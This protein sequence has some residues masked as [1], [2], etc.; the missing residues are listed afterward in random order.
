METG[1]LL[2]THNNKDDDKSYNEIWDVIYHNDTLYSIDGQGYLCA[3]K[4]N[5][6]T[7]ILKADKDD[8]TERGK[9]V[10][11]NDTLYVGLKHLF[12]VDLNDN[13]VKKSIQCPDD[14]FVMFVA[15]TGESLILATEGKNLYCISLLLLEGNKEY[16]EAIPN[17]ENFTT[18]LKN[19]SE[20]VAKFK[21]V[22]ENTFLNYIVQFGTYQHMVHIAKN[23]PVFDYFIG[24]R[25][26]ESAVSFLIK[27][28]KKEF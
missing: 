10:I 5:V 21:D 16:L 2:H 12:I 18:L 27:V 11:Y 22:R 19:Q 15:V 8:V 3:W 26:G 17:W 14:T 4:D 23:Y 28:T 25:Y 6:R 20:T 7:Q 13:K 9:L 1:Q 24:N